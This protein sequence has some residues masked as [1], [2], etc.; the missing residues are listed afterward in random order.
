MINV[1]LTDDHTLLVEGVTSAL[2]QTDDIRITRSF[3]TLTACRI[4][5]AKELPDVLLLDL[6]MPDGDGVEFCKEL[7][8]DYPALK[9]VVLTVHDEYSLVK[10]ALDSGVAG[11]VLKSISTD[12]LREAIRRVCKGERYIS[13]EITSLMRKRASNEV[14][15]TTREKEILQMLAE[16]L[17]SAKIAQAL[18]ISETTVKWHRQNLLS[19]FG[20]A[21]TGELVSTA[22]K[23]K[24]I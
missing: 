11:Y 19:K 6:S 4:A 23:K 14:S 15:L 8:R 9:V 3:A 18:F 1:Y 24:L 5:L 21:N 22:M 16:G 7:A 13:A 2:A 12:E 20:A 10:R 17:S